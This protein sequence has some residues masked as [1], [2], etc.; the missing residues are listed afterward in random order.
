VAVAEV[1]EVLGVVVEVPG[2]AGEDAAGGE[3]EENGVDDPVLIVFRLVAQARYQ[4]VNDEGEKEV[5]VVDVVQREHRA[6]VEEELGGE[7]LEAEVFEWDAERRLG[8]YGEDGSAG[9]K[10]AG[11]GRAEEAM[12]CRNGGVGN[13]HGTERVSLHYRS[14]VGV[15]FHRRRSGG[16]V[17]RM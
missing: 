16:N 9:E 11:Q 7:G 4:A 6:A 5:L 12:Q 13:R 17:C 8:L 3:F 14:R 2:G 15:M 10:K 1:P